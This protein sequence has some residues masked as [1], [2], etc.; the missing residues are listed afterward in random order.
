M[1]LLHGLDAVCLQKAEQGGALLQSP[2]FAGTGV[3]PFELLLGLHKSIMLGC[4]PSGFSA[5]ALDQL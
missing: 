1:E 3:G 2:D 5:S 4:W